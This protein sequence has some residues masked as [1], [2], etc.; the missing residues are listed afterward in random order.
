MAL[1]NG[2]MEGPLVLDYRGE[3]RSLFDEAAVT[4]LVSALAWASAE[5]PAEPGEGLVIRGVRPYIT[6]TFYPGNLVYYYMDSHW[7]FWYQG[8]GETDLY[9]ALV[10]LWEGAG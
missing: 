3:A 4:D 8:T 7:N 9:P 1:V 10:R 6:V 5:A 2:S